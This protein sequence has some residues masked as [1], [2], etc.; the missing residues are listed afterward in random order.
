MHFFKNLP[1]GLWI[2][3]WIDRFYLGRQDAESP[4]VHVA[5]QK[6]AIDD[7]SIAS[8]LSKEDIS[9]VLGR[10]PG[11]ATSAPSVFHT[12]RVLAGYL[13]LLRIGNIAQGSSIV[14]RLPLAQ[15]SLR[16]TSAS[17]IEHVKVSEE[18]TAPKDWSVGPY[19]LLN[20]FDFHLDGIED[21][22]AARCVVVRQNDMDFI[23]PKMVIFQAFYGIHSRV[24]NALCGGPWPMTAKQIICFDHFKS[25]IRTAIDQETGAWKIVLQTGMRSDQ[26]PALALLWFDQFARTQAESMFTDGLLQNRMFRGGDGRSWF[27]SANIPHRLGPR[28]FQMDVV[29]YQL[30]PFS[31]YA[32]T[33]EPRK[34]LV[35]EI[36]RS[37]WSLPEQRIEVEIANSNAEGVHQVATQEP[38]PFGRGRP[39]VEADPDAVATS[40]EDPDTAS[41]TNLVSTSTFEF[42]NQPKTKPQVKDTNK[43]YPASLPAFADEPDSVISAGNSVYGAERPSKAAAEQRVRQPSKQL[44]YLVEALNELVLSGEIESLEPLVPPGE[45]G[46]L[47]MRNGMPCWSFLTPRDRRVGAVPKAGWEV[48]HDSKEINGLVLPRRYARCLLI[49][50]V[51]IN[52]R[53]IILF[54]VEPRPTEASFCIYAF[55]QDQELV[56]W[57]VEQVIA[58]IREREGR[59]NS[60]SLAQVFEPLTGST[61]KALKHFY[62][63][64]DAAK[65]EPIG[66]RAGLLGAALK[67]TLTHAPK[68]D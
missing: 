27:A 34:F 36:S 37:T 32:P 10:R 16:L 30:R 35:T 15:K 49:L 41:S 63:Y 22:K 54:E 60:R 31:P 8:S 64:A 40:D 33:T 45:T 25:G 44:E 3:K 11:A 62:M 67:R 6:L 43:C 65:T 7:L 38:K 12:E 4:F 47:I 19:R 66:I 18:W 5:L 56:S 59:L 51:A 24:I 23:I 61:V 50:K 39:P 57:Y 2:I 58:E 42:I 17:D 1:P 28:P 13:P 21:I 26:A 9:Y 55:E 14:G 20:R 48:I 53:T 46:L 29:G 68:L 52:G